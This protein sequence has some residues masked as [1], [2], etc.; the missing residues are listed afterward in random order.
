MD[1]ST[2]RMAEGGAIGCPWRPLA[3]RPIF[4][5]SAGGFQKV[6]FH[7]ADMRENRAH[8]RPSP[9][10]AARQSRCRSAVAAACAALALTL[11]ISSPVLAAPV[12]EQGF[13][14]GL[15][16]W[17]A[18]GL[19][20]AQS[21][22]QTISV[23][24]PQVN[25]NLVTL[26]DSGGLPSAFG[27]SGVAWF[28]DASSGTFCGTAS[29][30]STGQSPKNGCSSV[31]T[32][33]GSLTSP[34]FSLAGALSAQVEFQAWWEIEGVDADRYD[35]MQVEYSTNGGS[36]WIEAGK[37]NPSDDANAEHYEPYTANGVNQAASWHRY[38]ADLSGA[39]G[40]STVRLRFYFDSDD[41]SYQGFRGWLVDNVKIE[42][43]YAEPAPR[44]DA[45]VP[46]CTRTG[47]GKIMAI[48]GDHFVLGSEVSLDGAAVTSATPSSERMEFVAP[49]T[50]LT[51]A[52]TVKVLRTGANAA[53]SNPATFEV[54]PDCAAKRTTASQLRCDRGPN[55]W[56]SSRCTATVG[57]SDVPTR[58]TPTGKVTFQSADGA[59]SK[60]F[61][62]GLTATPL[63]PGVSSCVVQNVPAGKDGFASVRASYDGSEIH[64]PSSASTGFIVAAGSGPAGSACAGPGSGSGGPGS[65][66]LAIAN[67]YYSFNEPGLDFGDV[68]YCVKNLLIDGVQG[69]AHVTNGVAT[70]LPPAA[71]IAA[72]VVTPADPITKG[73][74]GMAA[75]AGSYYAMMPVHAVADHTV[76]TLETTQQ[77]PPDPKFKKL[78][79]PQAPKVAKLLPGR[80]VS[81]KLVRKLTALTRQLGETQAIAEALTATLDRA[82]G[83]QL[84]GDQ[85]WQGRQMAHA[86]KLAR[87][88]S[89]QLDRSATAVVRF[90]PLARSTPILKRKYKLVK[91][92]RTARKIVKRGFTKHQTR[93]LALLGYSK[94]ERAKLRGAQQGVAKLKALPFKRPLDAYGDATVKALRTAAMA[95]RYWVVLPEITE[96]AKLGKRG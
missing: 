50:L 41:D 58:K 93:F 16:G 45:I 22:P 76:K 92:K 2:G 94:G 5:P 1:P 47:E 42:T 4:E 33:E 51:G 49:A 67:D 30:V 89:V 85:A 83:A 88:F 70:V 34:Q 79:K 38:V 19:W 29:H 91:I 12:V 84:A 53:E 61:S 21:S 32:Q 44:I 57:D 25:P 87:Q 56:D 46:D 14:G 10:H 77:D 72:A 95:Y 26:P 27:G 64:L 18:T 36:S 17:S 7:S 13:E 9:L 37:L 62:C 59:F 71:G 66:R 90:R 11:A 82:G 73:A 80:G 60:T 24:S 39:V 23:L 48:A 40:S 74:A 3:E 52:H 65:A 15:G 81:R 8:N 28:G 35:L 96:Q 63:S 55:P 78:A 6:V 68:G 69:A 31:D 20:H 86:I 75:G 43:P 54:R